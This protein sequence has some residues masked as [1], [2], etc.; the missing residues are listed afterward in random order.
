MAD[1]ACMEQRADGAERTRTV[2]RT[3]AERAQTVE[4][5]GGRGPRG[6]DRRTG[7]RGTDGA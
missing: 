3:G 1:D 6:A 4:R 5:I 7:G 2:G